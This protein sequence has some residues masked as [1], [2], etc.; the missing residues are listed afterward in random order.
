[1]T[2]EINMD[3]LSKESVTDS[4]QSISK[5]DTDKP[6]QITRN[7]RKKGMAVLIKHFNNRETE[8]DQEIQ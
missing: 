2:Q 3:V 6:Y 7:N 4:M 8:T 1:M 5:Q